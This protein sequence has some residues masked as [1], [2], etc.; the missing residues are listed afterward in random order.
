MFTGET[1]C[2][3]FSDLTGWWLVTY[4]ALRFSHSIGHSLESLNS[5][6]ACSTTTMLNNKTMPQPLIAM[7]LMLPFIVTYL[8]DRQRI[9]DVLFNPFD[10]T[11]L[12]LGRYAHMLIPRYEILPP[13]HRS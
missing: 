11:V 12:R 9:F 7:S 8:Y 3:V 2:V 10:R 1:V 13:G 4:V 6:L 5:Y